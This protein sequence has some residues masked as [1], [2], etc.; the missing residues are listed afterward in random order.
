MKGN[1]LEHGIKKEWRREKA[2]SGK[3]EKQK[4]GKKMK[5]DCREPGNKERN[6]QRGK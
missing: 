5:G 2:G 6:L 3:K 4:N 1:R